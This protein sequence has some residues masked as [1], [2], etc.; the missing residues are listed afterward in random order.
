MICRPIQT[1]ELRLARRRWRL[2][3]ELRSLDN[4]GRNRRLDRSP[5]RTNDLTALG[6][7]SGQKSKPYVRG[8]CGIGGRSVVA[9]MHVAARTKEGMRTRWNLR[10]GLE[11]TI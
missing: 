8:G 9:A 4:I 11:L 7:T 1:L 10:L 3:L 6:N 2:L 5:Q